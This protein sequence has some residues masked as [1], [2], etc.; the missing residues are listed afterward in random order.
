MIRIS[1][2]LSPSMST[3]RGPRGVEHEEK[4]VDRDPPE[5]RRPGDQEGESAAQVCVEQEVHRAEE[6]DD[7]YQHQDHP[8]HG[9]VGREN[10]PEQLAHVYLPVSVGPR[11]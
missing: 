3:G 5:R 10:A 7:G 2:A 4:A 9:E 6:H 11:R 8:G 1:K